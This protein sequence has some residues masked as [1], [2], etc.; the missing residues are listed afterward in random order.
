MSIQKRPSFSSTWD[1]PDNQNELPCRQQGA[2][3]FLAN[4]LLLYVRL[5]KRSTCKHA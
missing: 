5:I 4:T 2:N 3:I 1:P